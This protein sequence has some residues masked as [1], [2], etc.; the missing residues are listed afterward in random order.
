MD[1]ISALE[2]VP[3]VELGDVR[4]SLRKE[5]ENRVVYDN[6]HTFFDCL[7]VTIKSMLLRIQTQTNP[8]T[9]GETT[10]ENFK[11]ADFIQTS[12]VDLLSKK[13]KLF[14]SV[15]VLLVDDVPEK[16]LSNGQSENEG[17]MDTFY[18]SVIQDCR[19]GKNNPSYMKLCIYAAATCI[20][21]PIYILCTNE[22]EGMQWTYFK[23][24]LKYEGQPVA[25]INYVTMF[26]ASD[27]TFHTIESQDRATPKPI[28][29]CLVGMYLSFLEGTFQ[30]HKNTVLF[31][32]Y[33][34]KN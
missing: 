2:A 23:P 34:F 1:E 3:E 6:G 17:H 33:Y 11:K 26:M 15:L 25:V 27:S 10:I 5:N 31:Q 21:T 12:V 20:N 13:D 19:G 9:T 4:L 18:Q 16:A 30:F 24:L 8:R 22:T 28:A 14:K 29:S 32:K 7:A